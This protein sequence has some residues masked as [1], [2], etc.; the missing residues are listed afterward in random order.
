M[1]NQGV[2]NYIEVGQVSHDKAKRDHKIDVIDRIDKIDGINRMDRKNRKD[3]IDKIDRIDT[4][5]R[6]DKKVMHL[7]K[8]RS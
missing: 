4:E 6:I 8:I 1:I 5:V 7:E 3:K 2:I